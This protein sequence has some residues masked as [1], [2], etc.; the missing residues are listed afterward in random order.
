MATPRLEDRMSTLEATMANMLESQRIAHAQF[1]ENDALLQ[2]R[3]IELQQRQDRFQTQLEALGQRQ[4][5][6]QLALQ[7]IG[8]QQANLSRFLQNLGGLIETLTQQVWEQSQNI[9]S[10]IG[11]LRGPNPGGDE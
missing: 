3:N 8:Q 7:A 5:Q 10:L 6:F 9:S 1:M 4:D 11:A 2:R